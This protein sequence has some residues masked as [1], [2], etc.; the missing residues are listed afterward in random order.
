M[1]ISKAHYDTM[2]GLINSSQARNTE[3]LQREAGLRQKLYDLDRENERMRADMDWFKLRLN[4]VERERAMLIQDRL[5]VKIAVPEFVPTYEDPASALAQMPDFGSVGADARPE[6]EKS[7][8][9]PGDGVDYSLMPG[10][11]GKR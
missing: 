4:Q 11:S 5:G 6:P 7:D 9:E 8:A 3:M 2:D 10:Y 1:W